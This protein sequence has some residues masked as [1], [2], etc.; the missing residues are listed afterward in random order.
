MNNKNCLQDSYFTC[1]RI[2]PKNESSLLVIPT[3]GIETVYLD[4]TPELLQEQ[5]VD[6]KAKIQCAER[7]DFFI[8]HYCASPFWI[9]YHVG[10]VDHEGL[11]LYFF[12]TQ[13][14]AMAANICESRRSLFEGQYF[15]ANFE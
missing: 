15:L 3:S 11:R 2:D 12:N 8:S 5:C 10:E 7:L 4:V 1:M 6:H 14:I 9:W 13:Y